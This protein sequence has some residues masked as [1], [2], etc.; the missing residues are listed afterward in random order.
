[1]PQVRRATSDILLVDICVWEAS[2]R[3]CKDPQK[4]RLCLGALLLYG[5]STMLGFFFGG[6]GGGLA[7]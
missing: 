3:L 7:Q 2:E 1:M 5:G 4:I 6:W